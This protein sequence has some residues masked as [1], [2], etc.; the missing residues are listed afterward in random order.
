MKIRTWFVSNSSSS[1]FII[2]GHELSDAEKEL[3]DDDI[4]EEFENHEEFERLIH[5][6][7]DYIY[8]GVYPSWF[9]EN[10]DKTFYD[11]EKILNEFV[12]KDLKKKIDL[13][14][15]IYEETYYS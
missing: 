14:I 11:L 3:F 6:F 9:L 15:K 10:K 8:F 2:L 5:I 1:S 7:R 12:E 4:Y 13:D